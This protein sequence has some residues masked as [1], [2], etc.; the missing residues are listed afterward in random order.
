MSLVSQPKLKFCAH[1]TS[2]LAVWLAGGIAGSLHTVAEKLQVT[3][4]VETRRASAV[5]YKD[6]GHIFSKAQTPQFPGHQISWAI[7]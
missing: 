7:D 2:Y 6:D 4:E 5:W 1:Q 3:P